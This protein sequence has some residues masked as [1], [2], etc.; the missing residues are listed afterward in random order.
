MKADKFLEGLVIIIMF[1]LLVILGL[2]VCEYWKQANHR[3]QFESLVGT[4]QTFETYEVVIETE[5]EQTEE[6]E[7]ETEPEEVETEEEL[8]AEWTT[9]LAEI[10][11]V[12]G[13]K[14]DETILEYLLNALKRNDI[15]WWMPYAVAQIEAES[16]FNPYAEN[17]N[18]LDKGL[19]QYRVTYWDDNYS[20]FDWKRQIDLY[21]EQ[22]A[23]RIKSGCSIWETISRHKQSD[24]GHYDSAYVEY[25]MQFVGEE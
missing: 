7:V 22:T 4:E 20:I 1:C 2:I 3:R 13:R 19:L 24:F 9:D 8:K 15:E 12:N 5:T 18:G 17:P 10:Y 23:R 6:T 16:S 14:V 21:A 11:R 25:V